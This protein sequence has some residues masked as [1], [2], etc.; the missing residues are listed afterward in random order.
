[1]EKASSELAGAEAPEAAES[2]RMIYI[3]ST[4]SMGIVLVVALVAGEVPLS[5]ILMMHREL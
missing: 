2:N 4:L 1:M 5:F 3:S